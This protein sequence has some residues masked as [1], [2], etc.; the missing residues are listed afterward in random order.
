[1]LPAIDRLDEVTG[2]GREA[3]QAIIAEIGHARGRRGSCP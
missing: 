3:A 1:V 2:I